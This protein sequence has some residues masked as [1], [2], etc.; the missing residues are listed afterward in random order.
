MRDLVVHEILADAAYQHSFTPIISGDVHLTYASLY[1]RVVRLANSLGRLGMSP[2]TVVGVLDVNSHRYL[3]LTYALSMVRAV[4]HTIN[5]RL[6][7]KDLLWTL[8]QAHDE[9]LFLG[10]AFAELGDPVE[11]LVPRVVWMGKE[12]RPN[13]QPHYESLISDG[14]YQVPD[15]A[16]LVSPNDRYSLFYTTGT[17]GQPKG[18]SYTH[19][20]MLSGALQIAHHLALH[21]TGATLSSRDI[22]M[23]AIPFFHIHGWGVPFTA[24]YIGAGLV[25]PER[26]GPAQQRAL[27]DQ[28]GVTW[29]NM[30]PTQLVMLLDAAPGP[31]NLKIL[32]GGSPLSMGLA[33][34]A[35]SRGIRVSVIYGGSDQ[36]GSAISTAPGLTGDAQLEA[37][38]SWLT[39]FPMVR[40]EVRDADGRPVEP[41]GATLGEVWVQSP[42]LPR[43]YLDNPSAS[44]AAFRDGWFRSGD[45]ATRS[46]D[47]HIMV[48]DRMSDA[49]KSGGEW[50]VTSRVESIISELPGVKAVAVIAVSDERWGERPKAIIVADSTVDAHQVRDVLNRAVQ[51]GRLAKFWIPEIIDWVNELPMTSAGKI[52]KAKLRESS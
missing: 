37:L 22:I 48:W 7:L 44:D 46:P 8:Q 52:N 10:E 28:Y 1:E 39:P 42:W 4:I 9:W 51:A 38:A 34:R 16:S 50:I 21:D 14:R 40:I 47:G 15:S 11:S 31:L 24:P 17:T 36:L 49:V 30:V 18:L 32:T 2:G 23:P 33:R 12:L 45:L 27:I 41:D 13:S 26:G 5:F 6:P 43:G 25:L 19:R 29:S 20:Q 3:E 35:A